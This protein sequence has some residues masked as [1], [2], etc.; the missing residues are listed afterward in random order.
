MDASVWILNLVILA[1]VLFSDLGQRKVGTLRLLRPFITA[2][3]VV[4]FFIKGA[5]LSGNGLALEIAGAAAGLA[6]GV[7]AAALIRVRYD[8]G[9]GQAVSHAGLPYALVWVVVVGARLYFAYGANHVFGA[10]LGAWMQTSQISLGALTD[11]LIFLSIAMLLARTGVLAV[12]A[13]A[14]TARGRRAVVPAGVTGA[15]HAVS[16]R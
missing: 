5:A 11:S 3:A 1:A 16:A 4:P 7:L 2:A 8:A 6:L 13:R 15:R 12:K 9:A 10:S 14:A